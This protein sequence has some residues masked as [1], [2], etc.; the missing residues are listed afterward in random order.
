MLCNYHNP[1]TTYKEFCSA[2]VRPEQRRDFLFACANQGFLSI[3]KNWS[4]QQIRFFVFGSAAKRPINIGADSDLDVAVSGLDHKTWQ[5]SAKLREI[6]M[7]GLPNNNQMLPI[8]L[9]VFN[10]EKPETIIARG[11]LK[12]GTEIKVNK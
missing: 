7:Q 4:Q 2:F 3:R 6:F 9:V 1:I 8:D 5:C 11:I 12:N 10:A